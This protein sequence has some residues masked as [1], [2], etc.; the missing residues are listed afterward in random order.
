MNSTP[1]TWPNFFDAIRRLQSEMT[2]IEQFR[3]RV[4]HADPVNGPHFRGEEAFERMLQS[5]RRLRLWLEEEQAETAEAE[6]SYPI[7]THPLLFR[8]ALRRYE[9]QRLELEPIFTR[10]FPNWRPQS[11]RH[12]IL[13]RANIPK[14]TATRWRMKWGKDKS[15]R[16]WNWKVNHGPHNRLFTD[17][18]EADITERIR[19]GYLDDERLFTG[20]IFM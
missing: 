3:Q 8:P 18:D 16:P 2:N 5:Y 12:E 7:P 1:P 6:A 19:P 10:S 14:S 15:W 11:Y 17:E 4:I 20:D 13:P 9:K